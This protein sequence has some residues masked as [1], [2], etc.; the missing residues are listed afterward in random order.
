MKV[1]I[2]VSVYS[3]RRYIDQALR[4]AIG[5]TYRDIEVIVVDDGSTDGSLEVIRRVAATDRRLGVITQA[6]AG[7][8]A[9]RN[10]GIDTAQGEFVNLFNGDDLLYSHFVEETAG[11]LQRNI[12]VDVA[13]TSWDRIDGQG[14]K[15]GD[16]GVASISKAHLTVS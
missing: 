4:S 14:R 12:D 2:I 9:A 6:N 13:H 8:A 1:S 5:Q 10:R 3:K 11:F 16:A 7:A 15:I